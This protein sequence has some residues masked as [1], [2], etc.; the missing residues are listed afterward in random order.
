MM[1]TTSPPQQQQTSPVMMVPSQQHFN[2][3]SHQQQQ[4]QQPIWLPT[5]GS[6]QQLAAPHFQSNDQQNYHFQTYDQQNRQNGNGTHPQ[7]F[8]HHHHQHHGGMHSDTMN[9]HQQMTQSIYQPQQQ[10]QYVGQQQHSG[11]NGTMQ[12][13]PITTTSSS[14]SGSNMH[15]V[16]LSHHPQQQPSGLTSP[17]QQYAMSPTEIQQQPHPLVYNAPMALTS[18][19]GLSVNQ[20]MVAFPP[21]PPAPSVTMQL[22]GGRPQTSPSSSVAPPSVIL[23]SAPFAGSGT[24]PAAYSVA[25]NQNYPH[26]HHQQSTS[27]QAVPQQVVPQQGVPQY[28]SMHPFASGGHS[29][30]YQQSAPAMTSGVSTAFVTHPIPHQQH[31]QQQ[32]VLHPYYGQLHE[33]QLGQPYPMHQSQQQHAAPSSA[34]RAPN[35]P[36][37]VAPPPPPPL[38]Q[39]QKGPPTHPKNGSGLLQGT[40]YHGVVK[41]YNPTRGFGFLR[42][43]DGI[44][45]FVHQSCVNMPGFRALNVGAR[46]VFTA[47]VVMDTL[48]AVDVMQETPYVPGS[49]VEANEGTDHETDVIDGVSG[50]SAPPKLGIA[51]TAAFSIDVVPAPAAGESFSLSKSQRAAFNEQLQS[52]SSRSGEAAAE[53]D[54]DILSEV[55]GQDTASKTTPSDRRMQSSAATD[56]QATPQATTTVPR[57]NASPTVSIDRTV[58]SGRNSSRLEDMLRPAA[59]QSTLLHAAGIEFAEGLLALPSSLKTVQSSNTLLGGGGG[60]GDAAESVMGN[61]GSSFAPSSLMLSSANSASYL[62]ATANGFSQNDVRS[63]VEVVAPPIF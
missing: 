43:D 19:A 45:V 52:G 56:Q 63:P 54:N 25:L 44:D 50:G 9:A 41:R 21:P 3:P 13:I 49:G 7:T 30:P 60:G 11:C 62:Y 17:L 59:S 39:Q 27:Q 33:Q 2:N 53:D 40:Q 20:Q 34:R 58:G 55:R 6:H 48:Q 16:P 8:H 32:N 42:T 61:T 26:P 15:S 37:E 4:Q 57:D 18:S 23:S 31:Q 1:Q 38:Q 24:F 12:F 47:G 28:V 36:F 35:G 46:V 29:T 14:S 10:P 5:A 51:P 22:S